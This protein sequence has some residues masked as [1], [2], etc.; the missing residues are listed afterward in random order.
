MR[1]GQGSRK[2]GKLSLGLVGIRE[3]I[4][5]HCTRIQTAALKDDRHLRSL[6]SKS[7][8]QSA[9]TSLGAH[10]TRA[11]F[12]RPS[13]T[14]QLLLSFGYLSLTYRLKSKTRMADVGSGVEMVG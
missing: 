7:N 8:S 10:P 1:S 4:C 12:T 9:R 14:T 2:S 11:A 5:W 6:G 3:A 13:R